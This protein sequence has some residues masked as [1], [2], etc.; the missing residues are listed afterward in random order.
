MF[1]DTLTYVRTYVMYYLGTTTISPIND[2]IVIEG[3][4]TTITCEAI[5]YP[6]PTVFWSKTEGVIN[7]TVSVSDSI[8]VPTGY[9]NETRV[10]VNLT[11]ANA[12]RDDTGVYTCRANNSIGNDSMNVSITIQCKSLLRKVCSYSTYPLIINQEL[13]SYNYVQWTYTIIY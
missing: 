3:N 6:P 11:V 4:T 9:G 7:Y 13:S 8:S 12:Y 1:L 2:E 10:S 5:G